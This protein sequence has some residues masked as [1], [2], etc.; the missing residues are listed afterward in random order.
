[1]PTV[2]TTDGRTL[3]FP[4][5]MS[6]DSMAEALRALPPLPQAAPE[7]KANVSPSTQGG[8]RAV[9]DTLGMPVDL[10]SMAVN[11]VAAPLNAGLRLLG[12][13]TAPQIPSIT[14]PFLG[15][16]FL[17]KSAN[18]AGEALGARTAEPDS[19]GFGDR[20]AYE[21]T[22]LGAGALTGATEA[23]ALSN[24]S[25]AGSVVNSLAKA[26]REPYT[27]AA[28][29]A[30]SMPSGSLGETVAKAYQHARPYVQDAAMGLG[31]G[32]GIA[33]VQET[34]LKDSPIANMVAS[35]LG[36]GVGSSSLRTAESPGRML[37]SVVKRYTPDKESGL[38]TFGVPVSKALAER[39]ARVVQGETLNPKLAAQAIG[40]RTAEYT[41]GG[42]A[43]HE[44]PTTGLMSD[45][46][47]LVALERA[48]RGRSD[49]KAGFAKQD[50][51]TATKV[52]T[53]IKNLADPTADPRAATNYA[54]D[55]ANK[56]ELAAQSRIETAQI[57]KDRAGREEQ[58][59]GTRVTSPPKSEAAASRDLDQ[60]VVE[61]GLR[62]S[63]ETRSKLYTER[64]KAASNM[65]IPIKEYSALSESVKTA[66]EGVFT[67]ANQAR[68]LTSSL[69]SR[70]TKDKESKEP[71]WTGKPVTVGEF[72]KSA[73]A[74]SNEIKSASGANP[75]LNRKAAFEK[76]QKFTNETIPNLV[77]ASGDME[78]AAA[79]RAATKFDKES[80]FPT[81]G[82]GETQRFRE[83]LNADPDYQNPK[84]DGLRS[85]TPAS[86]TASRFLKSGPNGSTELAADLRRAIDSSQ[87]PQQGYE[88]AR[89]VILARMANVV[90]DTG[91]VNIA[92]LK[93]FI[94]DNDG[95]FEGLGVQGAG[96][97]Q[98]LQNTLKDAQ[99]RA[100][101][102]SSMTQE[103]ESARLAQQTGQ[104][105]LDSST[106]GQI[107]NRDPA[108]MAK[109]VLNSRDP[110]KA[111]AE[112]KAL[113]ASDPAAAAGFKRAITDE[114]HAKVT[115]P[116]GTSIDDWAASFSKLAKTDQKR[117]DEVLSQLY[118]PDERAALYRGRQIMAN[119]NNRSLR[120]TVGSN[121]AEDLNASLSVPLPLQVMWRL[122]RGQIAGG[123][124]IKGINQ[125]LKLISPALEYVPGVSAAAKADA[126]LKRAWHDPALMKHLLTMPTSAGGYPAWNKTLN[127]LMG[128]GAAAR[129]STD[130]DQPPEKG[131]NGNAGPPSRP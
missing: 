42:Y 55:A 84:P 93:K 8:L 38:G 18:K 61:K 116:A 1:M 91:K 117:F 87:T 129:E 25:K 120:G 50:K 82:R 72:T 10:A 107:R 15:S 31:A 90:D 97:R 60:A 45:D 3:Q 74:V 104:R 112:A 13:A 81:Y 79:S 2:R 6:Q 66:N 56:R 110:A 28:Q 75:N 70:I 35:I 34:P 127:R 29:R 98:E 118:S 121:T 47:G 32:S 100:A 48:Y 71:R 96:I 108:G 122:H 95:V 115:N 88:A 12:G 131:K 41:A 36:G 23:R 11:S 27:E 130:S 85:N 80:F 57:K 92:R 7:A 89:N 119:L 63:Q 106:L 44:M 109:T 86:A 37:S 22:R 33:A 24:V 9:A 68:D 114:I 21:G 77:E 99:G 4:D 54:N 124:E 73:P 17:A 76:V 30:A 26:I 123:G 43:P 65:V 113:F 14:E 40:D 102:T 128:L 83:D 52:G 51:A 67:G 39:V 78:A 111:M 125:A 103:L 105:E 5:G 49:T 46:A 101:K 19:M 20:V 64:D 69:G 94:L 59:L 62:P 126:L 58:R 16:E 53:D